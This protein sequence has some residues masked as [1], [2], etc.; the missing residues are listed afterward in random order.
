MTFNPPGHF[1]P[2]RYTGSPA[3]PTAGAE[4]V[5]GGGHSPAG[6]VQIGARLYPAESRESNNRDNRKG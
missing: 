1:F 5:A 3:T 6:S 2:G 4:H